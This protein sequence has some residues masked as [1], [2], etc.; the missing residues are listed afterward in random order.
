MQP[1]LGSETPESKCGVG[2]AQSLHFAT[3]EHSTT[4]RLF[5]CNYVTGGRAD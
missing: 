5:L 2:S 3:F 1:P 4:D